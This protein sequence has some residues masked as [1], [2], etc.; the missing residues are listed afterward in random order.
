MRFNVIEKVGDVK[1]F[2]DGSPG[3]KGAGLIQINECN[4]PNAHKLRTRI[5]TTSFYDRYLDRGG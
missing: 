2:G 4:I 3:G 1:I 5:L